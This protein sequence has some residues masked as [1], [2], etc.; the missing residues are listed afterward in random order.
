MDPL[1]WIVKFAAVEC[2]LNGNLFLE[3][4]LHKMKLVSQVCEI[5]H[6]N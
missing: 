3:I 6:E 5:Y 4:D 1:L 2:G